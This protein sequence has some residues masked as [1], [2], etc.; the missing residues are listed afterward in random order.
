MTELH[1]CYYIKKNK[2]LSS[3]SDAADLSDFLDFAATFANEWA[4]L[5]GRH[6][7]ANGDRW[8]AGGRTVSHWGA[9]VLDRK[10]GGGK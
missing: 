10:Q 8:F 7:E 4:T 9:Y 3:Q 1:N 6:N 5:T 2:S